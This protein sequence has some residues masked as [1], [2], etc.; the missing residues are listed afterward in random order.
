MVAFSRF[1]CEHPVGRTKVRTRPGARRN[2]KWGPASPP[3]PTQVPAEAFRPPSV[4][5]GRF[6][7]PKPWEREPVAVPLPEGSGPAWTS[8]RESG[9][10][11]G[12]VS[13]CLA[14]LP[15]RPVPPPLSRIRPCGHH[16]PSRLRCP[17]APV[18]F[19]PNCSRSSVGGSRPPLRAWLATGLMSW[20]LSVRFRPAAPGHMRTVSPIPESR[21]AQCACG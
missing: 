2:V 11:S 18:R 3:A 13:L 21:Q 4:P 1:A 16:G 12:L 17:R 14:L 10:G 15:F 20:S 5:M 9:F 8:D 19:R 6:L 7:R